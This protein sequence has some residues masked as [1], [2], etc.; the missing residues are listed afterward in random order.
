MN[1]QGFPAFPRAQN[2]E[3]LRNGR[4]MP[5]TTASLLILAVVSTAAIVYDIRIRKIP[6][7]ILLVGLAAHMTL[8]LARSASAYGVSM[9]ILGCITGLATMLPLFML[10]AIGA[11]DAKYMAFIGAVLGPY[12]VLG[13][14]LLTFALGGVLSLGAAIISRSLP[15]VLANM[16][17]M[18]LFMVAGHDGGMKISDV[19][20]TG[21]IP[22]AIAIASGTAAQ[23][24]LAGSTSWPFA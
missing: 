18:G 19:Q 6:N 1:A 15:Q 10:N 7:W 4:S 16:R 22:Y 5:T 12:Q 3:K 20:T 11:G 14:A 9:P 13:A 24:W 21:R 23:I 17:L 2:V 8:I